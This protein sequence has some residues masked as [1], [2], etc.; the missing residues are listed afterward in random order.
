MVMDQKTKKKLLRLT[1]R[2]WQA[3]QTLKDLNARRPGP[4]DSVLVWFRRAELYGERTET[5]TVEAVVATLRGLTRRGFVVQT[6]DPRD[7][8]NLWALGPLTDLL[9]DE[10][11]W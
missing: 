11:L 7:N 1:V 5:N 10:G 3:L 8:S 4:H 2:Q 6:H 9:Q